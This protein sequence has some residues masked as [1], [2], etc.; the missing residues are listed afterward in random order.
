MEQKENL[1]ING[2]MMFVLSL[3]CALGF[4]LLNGFQPLG[5]GTSVMDL[6]DFLV[7]N[8]ILPLGTLI[9]I[10]FCVSK[11]GWGWD[12]FVNEANTGKGLKIK[13]FMRPYMTYILP[14]IVLIV[15]VM[16]LYNFFNK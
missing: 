16:G 13:K 2:V 14:V 3:P 11:K 12:K 1:L 8:I 6:E 10:F 7:S 9:Y 15:F 4:N 5:E